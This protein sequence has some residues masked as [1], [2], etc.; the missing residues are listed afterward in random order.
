MENENEKKYKIK[1]Q[2]NKSKYYLKR[3]NNNI[4]RQVSN[5]IP[6]TIKTLIGHYYIFIHYIIACLSASI[7]L[8]SNNVYILIIL[9]NILFLDA[10]SIV[11]LHDCPLTMLE[12]R[13]LGYS[14]ISVRRSFFRKL[15]ICY[16]C[17]HDYEL[18]LEMLINVL[19]VTA[20]KI[21]IIICMNM[22]K[23]L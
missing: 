13:Y 15:G 9:L 19:S 5:N 20:C 1:K 8:F 12:T 11:V 14:S 21:M 23:N 6:N 2:K 22:T 18:Q 17:K 4:V 16:E 7:L 3:V 10:S